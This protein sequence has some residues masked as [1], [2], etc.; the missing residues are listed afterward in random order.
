MTHAELAQKIRDAIYARASD[1]GGAI[2]KE[3]MED[4]IGRVLAVA[5]P[6]APQ[7]TWTHAAMDA[8]MAR[9]AAIRA[10]TMQPAWADVSMDAAQWHK[11]NLDAGGLNWV[12]NIYDEWR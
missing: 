11:I 10:A 8:A 7:P 12:D 4:T 3:Q 5:I 6:A 9:Q 2:S 1:E